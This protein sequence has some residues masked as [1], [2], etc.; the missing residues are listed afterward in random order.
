M[1]S[2]NSPHSPRAPTGA[3]GEP[4]P[5]DHARRNG[6]RRVDVDRRLLLQGLIAGGCAA[7][8]WELGAS[9]GAV[10]QDE[11]IGPPLIAPDGGDLPLTPARWWKEL[12][13]LRVECGLCPKK[14][15]V[16]DLERGAC[17]VRENRGGRYY[18]LVHS[19]P[20]SIHIDPIEKKP[21]NHVLPGTP[22]L[23]LAT[24]GCNIECKF[25]QNWQ[26]AQ[27]RP[28]QVG[29]F[30]LRPEQVA[31]LALKHGTPTI[32]C[33]YTEPVVF[34]EYVYDVAV[35]ARKA[36]VRTVLVSNGFI[37]EKPLDDL[38]AVLGA[39]KVDLKAYTEKFYREVCGGELKPVLD[40]L[41]R[42]REK[43]MWTE[44]VVLIVP[45]LND[46]EEEIRGLARFVRGELGPDVPLH[47]TR[48]HPS[49]RIRN[50]PRTPVRTL[51]RA[52]EIA[53][54]EGLHFV[55]LG[56]IPGHPGNNTYCPRCGEIVIRRVGMAMVRNRLTGGRCHNCRR[57]IP[58]IWS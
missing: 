5:H 21:F 29:T 1:T 33:T 36:E 15:R 48:F 14:C 43:G 8:L 50:L 42:L 46:G 22:S 37:L 13:G 27:V 17:G 20:C 45:T 47:F 3:R 9:P 11:A 24:P 32:A 19:R 4:R 58:G 25:C 40:A 2:P 10:A 16:A 52:R 56:N 35:A 39:V 55:Y 57:V 23:S 26:I 18:T 41:R 49:Y 38:I 7:C 54:A 31:A 53:M 30:E 12:E 51:E 28:E 44:I 6:A 34:S